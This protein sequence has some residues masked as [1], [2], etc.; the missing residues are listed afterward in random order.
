M[1]FIVDFAFN[2]I[3]ILT[4]SGQSFGFV[5]KDILELRSIKMP[6]FSLFKS[7]CVCLVVFFRVIL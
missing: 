3:L 5:I 6:W 1:L 2:G 4:L 7:N